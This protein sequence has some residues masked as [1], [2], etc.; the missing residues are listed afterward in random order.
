MLQT[1]LGFFGYVK[2]PLEAVQLIEK[3]VYDL[4]KPNPPLD[5]ITEALTALKAM[6]RS[7]RRLG[8]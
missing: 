1:I 3:V 2:I 8:V 4:S 5:H 6:L 7:A